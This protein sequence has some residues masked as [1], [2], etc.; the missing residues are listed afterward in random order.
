MST[1]AVAIPGSRKPDPWKRV[2]YTRGLVLGVD[3]FVQEQAFFLGKDHLHNRM[4]HGY[5]TVAGLQVK[6]TGQQLT[7]TPGLALDA[8]GHEIRVCRDMCA[9]VGVWVTRNIDYLPDGAFDVHLVL[10]YRECQTDTVPVPGEPCRTQADAMA[11]SRITET[12]ELRLS[13]PTPSL[14]PADAPDGLFYTDPTQVG[15]DMVRAFGDLLERI[16]ITSDAVTFTSEQDLCQLV[17]DL[18]PGAADTTPIYLDPTTARDYLRAAFLVWVTEVRPT[19]LAEELG[20]PC[21]PADGA[22]VLL[23]QLPLTISGGTLKGLG[24]LSEERRPYLLHTRL[25]QEW[26][27]CGRE[28]LEREVPSE[29]FVSLRRMPAAGVDAHGVLRAWFHCPLLKTPPAA[30]VQVSFD[31]GATYVAVDPPTQPTQGA[32]VFL[33][34]LQAPLYA[35]SRL[36][37]RF[38]ASAIGLAAAGTSTLLD[39]VDDP[40]FSFLDRSQNYLYAYFA[41]DEAAGD[42]A[43]IYPDPTVV[44]LRGYDIAN[45][46]PQDGD[47]LAFTRYPPDT[48]GHLQWTPAQPGGD[49]GGKYPL[50]TVVGIQGQAV[51]AGTPPD[52]AMLA[53][54]KPTTTA[55]ANQWVPAVPA[56]DL[57]G[58]YP[59][60]T[61]VGLQTVPV[62]TQAPVEGQVL[63]Y[64][65]A[66]PADA[67]AQW[68]AADAAAGGATGPA[69]GDL[70][71]TYPN[72]RVDGLQTNPVAG[73]KPDP[74]DL[75]FWLDP[76][77]LVKLANG[78]T[79]LLDAFARRASAP[80]SA[81]LKKIIAAAADATALAKLPAAWTPLAPPLVRT[82][83]LATGAYNIVAAG[84]FTI[85]G[86]SVQPMKSGAA[87]F[88]VFNGLQ[89]A[90]GSVGAQGG[91]PRVYTFRGTFGGYAN[92]TTQSVYLVQAVYY[93]D[94]LSKPPQPLRYDFGD[95]VLLFLPG[96]PKD[97]AF[98]P[99]GRV[100]VEIS[101]IDRNA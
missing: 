29:T 10:C 45:K 35:S 74:W 6:L 92:P 59:G 44:R 76:Q 95:G 42:L 43:G 84:W 28:G 75:L 71:G 83:P 18:A 77:D 32:N 11:A 20:D 90:Q 87:P 3:E 64:R 94:D 68:M 72:P 7:V 86:T 82:P 81:Y 85:K 89:F 60:P 22:C 88:P 17:R 40:S 67:S 19:L 66:N 51:A 14:P 36:V 69:G 15:E 56:G 25:L 38:D 91:V 61:V 62:S 101:R 27:L 4:L 50:P 34:P 79:K 58:K 16:Q 21:D 53:S 41:C 37:L 1:I 8:A 39:V 73:G 49:L 80:V 52:G 26:L 9:D 65:K 48:S 55:P 5:G 33:I 2:N 78:D 12:F 24:K 30:A 57:G 98:T 13:V 99:S 23:A 93:P 63:T 46:A 97:D 54:M 96:E 70:A 47:G 31:D 100:T